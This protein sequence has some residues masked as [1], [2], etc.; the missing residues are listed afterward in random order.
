MAHACGCVGGGEAG[1]QVV[2]F[3]MLA[4]LWMGVP[5]WCHCTHY[6]T[7]YMYN[8]LTV[9]LHDF[10]VVHPPKSMCFSFAA[11]ANINCAQWVSDFSFC[12]QSQY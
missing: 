10:T 11:R 9:W 6:T 3:H 8:V 2:P 4:G 7:L 5:K 1:V 12:C